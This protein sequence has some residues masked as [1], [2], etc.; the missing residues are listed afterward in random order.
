MVEAIVTLVSTEPIIVTRVHRIEFESLDDAKWWLNQANH[1][2]V[3]TEQL[4]AD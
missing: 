1:F 4:K 3:C 2:A